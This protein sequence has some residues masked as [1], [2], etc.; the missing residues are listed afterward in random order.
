MSTKEKAIKLYD[1]SFLV[2]EDGFKT[3][4]KTKT[5]NDYA[6]LNNRNKITEVILRHDY[7]DR[8]AK[9]LIEEFKKI[10]DLIFGTKKTNDGY[11][12]AFEV[13][14][15]ANNY[16]FTYEQVIE[17]NVIGGD[18]ADGKI[19]AVV[20]HNGTAYV[21][22][23]KMASIPN[24]QDLDMAKDNYV[25]FFKSGEISADNT[26]DL[27]KFLKKNKSHLEHLPKKFCSISINKTDQNNISSKYIIE[28]YFNNKL[29]PKHS[30][31]LKLR[32]PIES[33]YDDEMGRPVDN[34]VKTAYT[35]FLFVNAETLLKDLFAQGINSRSDKLFYE[36]V[37]GTLGLN[38]EMQNTIE[39][40]PEKFELY[41]N[42]LSILGTSYKESAFLIV[43]NPMIING[44]QTLYNLMLA[45]ED[46]KNLDHILIPVFIKKSADHQ[47][48]LNIAKFNNTQ[49]QV[50]N[51]DL[52]SVNAELRAIQESF[53]DKANKSNF[54]GECYYLNIVS[55]GKRQSDGL[56]KHLFD[57]NNRISLNDFVRLYCIIESNKCLGEWK[58]NINRMIE[59]EIT[60]TYSFS[61]DK[62]FHVCQIIKTFHDFLDDQ[63]NDPNYMIADVAFMY[64]LHFYDLKAVKKIIDYIN[65][66]ICAGDE[67]VAGNLYKSK[68]IMDEIDAAKTALKIEL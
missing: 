21:F 29:L 17:N 14:A 32:L 47:E 18:G 61:V 28:R 25:E 42:G 7:G 35:T 38:V 36:N 3:F 63:K 64:L 24:V 19:D 27:L 8:K 67:K 51:I 58:N 57:K 52:L 45:K 4:R 41:N 40:A 1:D 44:Q 37:R 62:A 50:R 54:E 10:N 33:T 60:G 13:F 12:R 23:I 9:V 6:V 15:I 5:L 20:A 46:G 34:V 53:L 2:S 26:E 66:V 68:K 22:Q 39:N 59:K 43:E 65:V 55:S 56:I 31:N 48:S 49:R 16:D 30:N 11:G